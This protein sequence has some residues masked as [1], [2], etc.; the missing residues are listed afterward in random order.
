[1]PFDRRC[2]IASRWGSSTPIQADTQ[3][4]MPCVIFLRA[5]PL[6]ASDKSRRSL[7]FGDGL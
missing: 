7:P 6:I 1:M 2:G 5:P 4:L 3:P